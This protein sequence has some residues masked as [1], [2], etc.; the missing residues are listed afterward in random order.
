[1]SSGFGILT[2]MTLLPAATALAVWFARSR[3]QTHLIAT[4]GALATLILSIV[5]FALYDRAAGGVQ[6]IDY[7]A[8][9]VGNLISPSYFVGVDGL[10]APLVLLTGILSAAAIAASYRIA[11]RQKEYFMW[12][13]ILETAVMG[14]FV[15]LDLLQFFI[16]FEF[17]ILPMYMLISIWGSGQKRYSAMKFAL[18]TLGG[19]A[20][21]LAAI[22]LL[23]FSNGVNTLAMVSVPEMGIVGI[24]AV[25]P[26]AELAAPAALIFSFFLV[27]FAVKLPVW[28]VHTWL[29]NA[30]TDAPTAAS[31]MLAGVLLKM[32]GYGVYRICLGFFNSS[33]G[34]FS[35]HDA[36]QILAWFAAFSTIYGAVLTLRQTDLK[37]MVAFSSVSHMGFVLLGAAAISAGATTASPAGLNGGALQMFTHG[38]ITGLLFLCVGMIYDRLHT[39][40]I[41]HMGALIF[42]LPKAAILFMFAGLASLGLPLLAGFSAEILVFL[43]AFAVWPWQTAIAAFSVVLAAGYILITVGKVFLGQ[44]PRYGVLSS[45]VYDDLRDIRW[46]ELAPGILLLI[47]IIAIGLWPSLLTDVF[48]VGINAILGS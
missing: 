20:F 39:R 44:R 32:G 21:M 10:S 3:R 42:K 22:L 1:M 45:K 24:P 17:E 46:F 19:G 14:V 48:E 8:V 27:A 4:G 12:L 35:A 29:P 6:L 26:L 23:F 16:F 43:G 5:V 15:S 36:A 25:L 37:R 11:H 34:G 33:A 13:L 38:A 41:P 47:P 30:H 2:I 7:L 28:P 18:F 40:Y 9:D 31:I